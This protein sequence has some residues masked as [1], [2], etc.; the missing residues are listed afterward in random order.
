[1]SGSGVG[2]ALGEGVASV[3]RAVGVD[4]VGVAVGLGVSIV[5]VR[6]ALAATGVAGVAAP[7]AA[8]TFSRPARHSEPVPEIEFAV[9]SRRST[10]A[11]LLV[12]QRVAQTRA[13]APLTCAAARLVPSSTR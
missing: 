8:P 3:G 12:A 1:M 7:T 9:A 5:G 4:G 11:W 10:T 13:A 2:V 6:L